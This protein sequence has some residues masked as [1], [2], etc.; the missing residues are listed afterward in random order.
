MYQALTRLH[1]LLHL[2]KIIHLLICIILLWQRLQFTNVLHRLS[3]TNSIIWNLIAV[4]WNIWNSKFF[5]HKCY[6]LKQLC[7]NHAPSNKLTSLN[8][9]MMSFL[10][11]MMSFNVK[12]T[13]FAIWN[14]LALVEHLC[15]MLFFTIPNFINQIIPF[16]YNSL[17]I[18]Q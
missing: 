12:M 18:I 14:N 3:L 7:R 1:E 4:C 13:Q 8:I 9:K 2:C 17:C 6:S 16:I 11:L 15:I 10:C 5:L